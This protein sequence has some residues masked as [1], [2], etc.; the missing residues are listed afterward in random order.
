MIIRNKRTRRLYDGEIIEETE[1]IIVVK[2][3]R[4]VSE[5]HDLFDAFR[6]L[7]IGNCGYE[8]DLKRKVTLHFDKRT[9]VSQL[10]NRLMWLDEDSD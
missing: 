5:V 10:I 9:D 8:Y 7:A 3:T 6:H 1:I 2:P 4:N